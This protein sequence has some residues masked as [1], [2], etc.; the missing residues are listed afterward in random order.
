VFRK[1][2]AGCLV[3]MAV[4]FCNTLNQLSNQQG[5]CAEVVEGMTAHYGPAH[6]VGWWQLF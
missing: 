2:L 5:L 1:K 3:K 6:W 4:D